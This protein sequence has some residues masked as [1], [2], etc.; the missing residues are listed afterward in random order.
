MSLLVKSGDR[1]YEISDADLEQ[2]ETTTADVI[3]KD[4]G[5][6]VADRNIVVSAVATA[7]NATPIGSGCT[8]PTYGA[9]CSK[10]PKCP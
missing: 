1:Y 8:K 6:V 3:G 4:P 10:A 7:S 5:T 9:S 2:C